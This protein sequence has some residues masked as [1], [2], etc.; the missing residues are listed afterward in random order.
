[1]FKVDYGNPLQVAAMWSNLVEPGDNAAGLLTGVLGQAKGLEW[2]LES[3]DPKELPS[4]LVADTE[5]R[6]LPWRQAIQRWLP[7]VA[8]ANIEQQFEYLQRLGGRLMYP[9]HPDWPGQLNDLGEYAPLALWMRGNFELA[10]PREWVSLVGAR[11]STNLGDQL[12]AEL[13][14]DLVNAGFGVVSG[15]A[16]GIDTAAHRGALTVASQVSSEALATI[17]FMAG[18]VGQ[19]YPASQL[20]LFNRLLDVGLVVSEV[21][22]SWRPARWRFLSRNRLI[23]AFSAATVVVEAGVRSGALATAHRALE[24]GRP[25]G[26][27]PGPVTS[28]MSFGCHQLIRECGVTLVTNAQQVGELFLGLGAGLTGGALASEGVQSELVFVS[29]DFNNP[30]HERVWLALPKYGE[31]TFVSVAKVAGLSVSEVSAAVSALLV[32][33]KVEVFGD[34]CRRIYS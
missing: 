16:F 27:V 29:D 26:A 9:Q 30:V 24:L 7:R 22:P 21:P 14:F 19:L 1:M 13:S 25:V 11:A 10:Q 32:A 12:A 5:G 18:G 6:K 23:A 31:A 3:A 8:E 17:A 15:G 2:V 33:G 4:E 34:K 28:Q 20:D